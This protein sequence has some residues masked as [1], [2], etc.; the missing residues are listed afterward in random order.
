MTLER[1]SEAARPR[2]ASVF[3]VAKAAGVSHQTVSRVLNEHPS[4]RPAT[5]QKVLDAMAALNYRPN[6]AARAL[7]TS[8]SRIIGI[9]STSS[10][11]YGPA[12]S[13]AGVEA[14]ARSRGYSVNIANADGSDQASIDEAL[15][16]LADLSVEG[17][18]VV[19]PQLHVLAALS[20]R[21][22][23]IP[24][25]TL[26]RLGTLPAGDP[27]A[28]AA[29]SAGATDAVPSA[30]PGTTPSPPVELALDQVDGARMATAHLIALGHRRI[31]HVAG[32]ADW[33]DASSRLAGFEA[34]MAANG[35]T[36]TAVVDGD[37]SATSGFRASPRL[38][39]SGTTA[40]FSSNDQMAL[41]LIHAFHVAG[42]DLP[43][44]MSVVGFDD[45]P[46]AEHFWPPLTTVRQDFDE[47]GRRCVAQLLGDEAAPPSVDP[48]L[49]DRASSARPE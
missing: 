2:A 4:V 12:S 14:A 10:G 33:V 8:R 45:I 9:L 5:K 20:T 19:A 49:V 23:G 1:N 32:P 36:A 22:F 11:E 44:Q 46:E 7:V 48:S 27:D 21:S 17:L 47:L 16:H 43:R 30:D 38:L 34:E 24:Y 39:E 3:D 6:L 25:V 13:I 26:Q 18:V 35:L 37:W 28:A 41:G 29:A 15:N 31:A 40:V 42:L